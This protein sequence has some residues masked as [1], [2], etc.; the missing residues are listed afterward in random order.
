MKK[1]KCIKTLPQKHLKLSNAWHLY[2]IQIN[3]LSKINRDTLMQKLYKRGILTQ[4]HYIPIFLQPKYF[5]LKK[6]EKFVG[7]MNFFKDTVSIPIYPKLSLKEV[8]NI[9]D[10]INKLT[11]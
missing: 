11:N 7:A 10:L 2:F 8:K 5:K 4:V 3:K 1:N 9:G 6:K